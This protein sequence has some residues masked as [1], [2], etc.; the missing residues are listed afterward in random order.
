MWVMQE[1]D[2]FT[3]NLKPVLFFSMLYVHIVDWI[4][5]IVDGGTYTT[6]MAVISIFTLQVQL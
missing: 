5:N 1:Y 2:P 3:V 6:H 4:L